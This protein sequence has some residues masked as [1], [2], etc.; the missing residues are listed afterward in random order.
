MK[1]KFVYPVTVL[2]ARDKNLNRRED[3][4]F[5]TPNVNECLAVLLK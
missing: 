1:V 5:G 2:I 3:F 4:D